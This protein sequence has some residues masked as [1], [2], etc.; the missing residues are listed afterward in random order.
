MKQRHAEY[1][2]RTADKFVVRLPDG[3]RT[4]L[5]DVARE[6]HRSMNSEIISRL[7]Q[8]LEA[9]TTAPTVNPRD[10]EHPWVPT[11]GTPAYHGDRLYIIEG[12]RVVDDNHLQA[13]LEG[14]HWVSATELTPYYQ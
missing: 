7:T 13:K 12:L 3:M 11:M 6:H 14:A 1:N 2:S 8:S 5:A 4:K 9:G 10:P